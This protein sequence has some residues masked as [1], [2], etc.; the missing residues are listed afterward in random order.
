MI[1]L[2][3]NVLS[4]LMRPQN[5]SVVLQWASRKSQQVVATTAVCYAE[6]LEGIELLPSGAR[7]DRLARAMKDVEE[8]FLQIILPFDEVSARSYSVLSAGLRRNGI[9]IGQADLMIASI[10]LA[11]QAVLATRNVRHFLPTGIR[12]ENPF[13]G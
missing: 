3:T 11:Q 13:D 8:Q 6:L 9:S 7:K 2:D 4:E 1:I 10:C 5:D 12:V